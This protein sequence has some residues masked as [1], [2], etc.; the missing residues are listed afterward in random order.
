MGARH[1]ATAATVLAAALL[2]LSG[3]GPFGGESEEDKAGDTVT[4]LV[5][6]R[7]HGDFARVCELIAKSQLAKFEQAGTSCERALPKLAAAGSSTSVRIDEA[8]VQ[9][10]RA[11]VDATVSRRGQ[12]GEAQT[13][14][15][16]KEDGDWKV[17]EVGF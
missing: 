8:R 2:A 5:E 12:G 9:G 3:C 6:A 4:E 15:L 1:T 16:V 13:I 10:D 11:T 7:N 14:L 17:A